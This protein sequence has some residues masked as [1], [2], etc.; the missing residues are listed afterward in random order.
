V[1]LASRGQPLGGVAFAVASNLF[2]AQLRA[3][4][5]GSGAGGGEEGQTTAPTC[6]SKR[7]VV[8]PSNKHASAGGV[9]CSIDHFSDGLRPS[10]LRPPANAGTNDMRGLRSNGGIL[11]TA[12]CMRGLTSRT[13]AQLLYIVHTRVPVDGLMGAMCSYS[14]TDT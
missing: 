3:S 8:K 11:Y 2:S 7:M 1:S 12:V 13:R 4:A 9:C 6:G 5:G 10:S 14:T